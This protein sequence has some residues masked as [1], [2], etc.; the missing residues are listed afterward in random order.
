MLPMEGIRVVEA[1]QMVAGPLAGMILAEQGADVVKV[2]LPDGVGDRMRFLG[3]RRGDMSALYHGVNRGKRSVAIDSK[4]PDGRAVVRELVARSDVFVQNFRPGVA[5]RLGLGAEAL[6]AEQPDLVYVSVSGFGTSGPRCGEK[7]Y[8]YVIQ[9]MCGMAAN[10]AGS[11]GV[12]VLAKHVVIDKVTA[13]TVS[14]AITAALFHRER[15][16]RG[17]HVELNMLD[18]ALWFFWPDGMMDRSLLGDDVTHAPHFGALAEIRATKDGF[19]SLIAM[20]GRTWPNLVAAFEP[21]WEHDPRFA[22]PRDRE[23]HQAVL[24]AELAGILATMSTAECL[25]RMA[26]HDI[27][28]AAVVPVDA[29]HTDPQ[30]VHNDTLVEHDSASVGRIREPRPPVS[31]DGSPRALPGPAP[32]VGEH[33]A[34]VLTELGYDATA[35]ARLA[36][37]GALGP[38]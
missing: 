25:E 5:E 4:D 27:P 17:Q 29:V 8:D 34:E 3:S 35:I 20:G 23:L 11:D 32:R 15:T 16:G 18:T 12:P 38:S 1:A 30:V 26:A 21:A 24:D 37:R 13:L 36:S 6:L 28:G 7:V 19:V 2:E 9:A 10:Q 31:F 33:T 22:T 14:Q